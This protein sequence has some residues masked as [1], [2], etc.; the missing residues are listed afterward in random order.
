[1]TTFTEIYRAYP[2]CFRELE[3][4]ETE[5]DLADEIDWLTRW[6]GTEGER[7]ERDSVEV[8]RAKSGIVIWNR[9]WD[10]RFMVIEI[11]AKQDSG[12]F[13]I[14]DNT[15]IET[16]C[17]PMPGDAAK[18]IEAAQQYRDERSSK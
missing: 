18:A 9:S 1:M 10:L 2:Y 13:A 6:G 7:F 8:S 14:Y 16:H 5:Q 17:N 11:E 12:Y 15:I 3:D 4:G